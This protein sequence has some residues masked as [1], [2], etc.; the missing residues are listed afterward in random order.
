MIITPLEAQARSGRRKHH[1]EAHSAQGIAGKLQKRILAEG[2]RAYFDEPIA[3][4]WGRGEPGS[5]RIATMLREFY[6][7]KKMSRRELGQQRW[8]QLSKQRR[9]EM[10]APYAAASHALA[11]LAA[12]ELVEK[13]RERSW[14]LTA[15]GLRIAQA[16]YPDEPSRAEQLRQVRAVYLKRK[17][18]LEAHG[19]RIPVGW[20][21][22]CAD[23][24]RREEH[25]PKTVAT[26]PGVKVDLDL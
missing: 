3:R 12:E 2:L 17:A 10:A 4:A 26:T 15:A 20:R 13:T 19:E 22:F 11:N 5:F 9:R 24:F 6:A 23:C 16:L 14:R 21:A 8:H 1:G 18:Y 25:E 7:I